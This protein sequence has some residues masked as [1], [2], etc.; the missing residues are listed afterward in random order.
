MHSKSANEL[1][2]LREQLAHSE[3]QLE[4]CRIKIMQQ[5]KT[6][7]TVRALE[8]RLDM[9]T[10]DNDK[11]GKLL[12]DSDRQLKDLKDTRHSCSNCQGK[13]HAEV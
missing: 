13:V 6:R 8:E 11:L 3:R 5:E 10:N 7:E 1:S 2:E 9:L 4:V 12:V